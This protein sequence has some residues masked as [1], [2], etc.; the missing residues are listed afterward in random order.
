MKKA[1]LF[2]LLLLAAIP[3]FGQFTWFVNFD[4]PD[5]LDRFAFDTVS[6]PNCTWQIGPP[7]KTIFTAAYNLPNAIVTDTMNAV[8]P[9]DTSV[10]YLAH[11]RDN[12]APFHIFGLH[13]F[14][15]MDGDSTDFGTIEISP[16][17]GLN[18]VNVLTQDSAYDMSWASPKPTLRGSTAGWTEFYLLMDQW[19][20]GWGG[21]PIPMTADTIRFRFTYITDGDSAAHD[22]WMMDDFQF[23]DWW[24]GVEDGSNRGWAEIYPNP[25]SDQLAVKSLDGTAIEALQILN[26]QGKLVYERQS[27]NGGLIDLRGFA[28]G[29]YFLRAIGSET[30]A[31][32]L[33]F[34]RH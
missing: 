32:K 1:L 23:E 7:N 27:D 9:N 14:Y 12:F 31:G 22:G 15:Q 10:F 16:D 25:A 30:V 26:C 24:E 4:T 13:F 21:A 34:V 33:F 3:T 11:L 18:W 8:P 20:S 19:A 6:N 2:L 17:N 29:V 28:D 5:F